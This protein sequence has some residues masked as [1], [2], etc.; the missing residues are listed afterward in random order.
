L[1]LFWLVGPVEAIPT[2]NAW[3]IVRVIV[4]DLKL[5]FVGPVEAIPTINARVIVRVIVEDL[6][7]YSYYFFYYSQQ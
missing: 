6:E 3:V 2:I 4:E 5:W 1:C 7:V